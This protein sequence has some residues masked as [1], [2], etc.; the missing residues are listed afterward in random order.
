V[1]SLQGQ[2][3]VLV[4]PSS[5]FRSDGTYLIVGGLRGL[6]LMTAQWM[7]QRG[8]RHLVLMGR[9]GA[10]PTSEGALQSMR[11]AGAEVVVARADVTK[12]QQVA[13]V[14]A[15]I[16]QSMPSLRGIIHSA[17]VLDDA[18]LTRLDQERLQSVMAP[19]VI[20]AWNLHR[21]TLDAPLD[22]Y[23][24]YSSAASLLGTP[25]Q[26]NYAAANAFVDALAHHRRAQGLPAQSINWGL[27][28]KVGLAARQGLGKQ[29]EQW[30]MR[31]I[32]PDQGFVVIERL[33]RQN[34][35]QVAVMPMDWQQLRRASG[36]IAH[37]PSMFS[38]LIEETVDET[39]SAEI[40]DDFF[41]ELILSPDSVTRLRL[42]ETYLGD[43]VAQALRVDRSELDLQCPINTLGMDSI[44]AVRLRGRIETSLSVNLSIADLLK[45]V[46]VAQLAAQIIP[47]LE[48]EIAETLEELE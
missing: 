47:Q 15:E 27:W 8:A 23:I 3:E 22:F 14:M 20:G 13:N 11:Q 33:F 21:L 44:L 19:K 9:S 10:P 31:T 30:G 45:G 34:P 7:V 2:E 46:S 40:L 25:G 4:A 42:L 36:G 17:L 5:E 29:V 24:L 35:I 48:A 18:P 26:G 6:G 32:P 28:A 16:S 1:V 12:E 39:V 38:D 37:L 41:Q 43:L